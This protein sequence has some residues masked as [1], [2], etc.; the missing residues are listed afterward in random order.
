MPA[1]QCCI[2]GQCS[3]CILTFVSGAAA[4][5]TRLVFIITSA[6]AEPSKT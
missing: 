5:K 2:A 1:D 6:V 3:K 4:P